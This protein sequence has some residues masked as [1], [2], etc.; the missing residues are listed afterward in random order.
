MALPCRF[1]SCRG[2]QSRQKEGSSGAK[3][4]QQMNNEI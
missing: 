1:D 2:M 4:H 3:C